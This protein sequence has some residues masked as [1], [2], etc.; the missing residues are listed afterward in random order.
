MMGPAS[1]KPR[2]NRRL[3]AF[4]G[5]LVITGSTRVA[6]PGDHH[7]PDPKKIFFFTGE[8]RRSQKLSFYLGS[9][10]EQIGRQ[11]TV[12]EVSAL[13]QK[14]KTNVE[15]MAGRGLLPAY[16]CGAAWRFNPADLAEW[17]KSQREAK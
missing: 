4:T 5:P 14:T 11:L 3:G 6:L 12:L 13:L 9:M 8:Y 7:L 2:Q 10:E 15:M 17:V 16:K 1:S